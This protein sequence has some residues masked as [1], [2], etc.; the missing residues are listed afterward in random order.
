MEIAQVKKI[1]INSGGGAILDLL[2]TDPPYN[3]G[4]VGG[5]KEHLT[6]ENDKQSDENFNEFL[7]KAFKNA[8]KLL[9]KGGAYYVWYASRTHINFENA[10]VK[11]ELPVRE[12]LIWVKNTF[13]LGRQ[14]YQWQHEPCLYGWKD[15]AS[16][17]FI[18]KRN[19]TTIIEDKLDFDNMKKDDLKKLLE[20]I[21]EFP[22]TIIRENKPVASREHPTM[23]PIRM[24][25]KLI[26]NSTKPNETVLDLFGGSGS[27]LIA[28]E[29]LGR[30][31]Y[32]MEYDPKYVD[33]IIDRW[34]QFTGKK[35]KKIN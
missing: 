16:H 9:R 29:Q 33:V 2:F 26:S 31:C 17:Y 15:G 11:A 12:Q 6:I 27:T 23:K 18:D 25:A 19:I 10:L 20:E 7:Y 4:I 22:S 3:V 30:K 5:T 13:V 34:E 32:M 24:C 14:D 28:C 21:Y 8:N 35:A 1:P